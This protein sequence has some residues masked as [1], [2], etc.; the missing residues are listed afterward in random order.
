[1]GS[2]VALEGE[3]IILGWPF[4]RSVFSSPGITACRDM[5]LGLLTSLVMIL[6]CSGSSLKPSGGSLSLVSILMVTPAWFST[7]NDMWNLGGGDKSSAESS[8]SLLIL[9]VHFTL[10]VKCFPPFGQDNV[11]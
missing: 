2:P 1:M 10:D 8:K 9:W 5:S 11:I 4:T 7:R 6:V 3:T